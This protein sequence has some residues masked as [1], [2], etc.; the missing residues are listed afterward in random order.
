MK[1]MPSKSEA[2]VWTVLFIT[3]AV[4]IIAGNL[5]SIVKFTETGQLHKRSSYLLINLA[6]ADI[7][8]G[9]CAIPMWV[10]LIGG[11]DEL[12]S[13]NSGLALEAYKAIDVISG[14]GSILS[15]TLVSLERLWATLWPL[16]HRVL[17]TRTYILGIAF[18][19]LIAC[20]TT[21]AGMTARHASPS[22][23]ILFYISVVIL[24]VCCVTISVANLV[25]WIHVGN[26]RVLSHCR[27]AASQ[28]RRLTITLLVVTLVS[29]IA[30]LP[31][32]ILNMVNT[33][34]PSVN[35]NV[36]LIYSAKL[37]HYGNSCAN[38]FVYSLRIVEFR[39]AFEKIF[40]CHVSLT[41]AEAVL[42]QAAMPRLSKDTSTLEMGIL[43]SKFLR[44]YK[45]RRASALT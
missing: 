44:N 38:V 37:L 26:R 27:N 20:V 3:E 15:L 16:R 7:L 23:R 5:F 42:L 13:A 14:L 22:A 40:C 28:E 34:L 17:K 29:L 24:S 45:P 1:T 30:W 32:V 2:I 6:A 11:Q 33:F 21:A 12:W 31:F 43:A 25:I 18:V 8:V 9:A 36:T 41:D 35:L 4:A 39:K 10:Y 19:W